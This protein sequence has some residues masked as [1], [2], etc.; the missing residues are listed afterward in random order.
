M[1]YAFS[2]CQ[3]NGEITLDECSRHI[4]ELKDIDESTLVQQAFSRMYVDVFSDCQFAIQVEILHLLLSLN[5]SLQSLKSLTVSCVEY[6]LYAE[7]IK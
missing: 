2:F 6:A 1:K 7:M 5:I 4:T 3:E